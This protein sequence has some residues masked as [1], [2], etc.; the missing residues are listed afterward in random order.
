M[1]PRVGPPRRPVCSEAS[2]D[3]ESCGRRYRSRG[4]G[5]SAAACGFRALSPRH[6]PPGRSHAERGAHAPRLERLRAAA[7]LRM[8]PC[9]GRANDFLPGL[10]PG[11]GPWQMLGW[12]NLDNM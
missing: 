3:V 6:A 5:E 9:S 7:A 11:L 8:R 2:G 4:R 12:F 1:P 10:E